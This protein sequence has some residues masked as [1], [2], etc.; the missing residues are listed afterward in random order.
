MTIQLASF[1]ASLAFVVADVHAHAA[2][3]MPPAASVAGE[4]AVAL[5]NNGG[6]IDGMW[7]EQITLVNCASGAVLTSF[8]A[9]NLFSRDG[10]LTAINNRPPSSNT[11]ATGTW[12]R[13]RFGEFAGQ[14]RFFR[15]NPDGSY[16]GFNQVTRN[17]SLVAGSERLNGSIQVQVF[18]ANDVL[19]QTSCGTEDGTRVSW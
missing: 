13:T 5:D 17:L 2:A 9:L 4:P 18:D 10:S 19:L 14:M 3:S 7:D 16:A 6:R 1:V 8:R 12:W 15:F 11:P